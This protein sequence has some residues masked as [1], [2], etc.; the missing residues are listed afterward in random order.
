MAEQLPFVDVA[1]A[2]NPQQRCACVLVL[3]VS[4]SM[5]TIVANAGRDTG[6]TMQADGQTFRVVS[7]GTTRM[8][9]LNQGLQTL[10]GAL[11]E[12]PLA[13][14][15]VELAVVTFGDTVKVEQPFVT[16]A[17]FTP[18]ALHPSSSGGTPMG[19]AILTAIELIEERKKMYKSHSVPYLRPW[20]FLISDGMP[21][22]DWSEAAKRI[23]EYEDQKK[24]VFFAILTDGE[25][26]G[27][28]SQLSVRPVKRVD[29]VKYKELFEWLS[30]T[31]KSMSQSAP[32]SELQVKLPAPG[33]ETV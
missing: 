2:T 17:E 23:R 6:Q 15:R 33:W 26:V 16:A 11:I 18:P 8:D 14:Q 20:L 13:S 25:N 3:D 28:L 5:G 30:A 21:D 22:D 24:L 1:L 4:G 31:Q 10:K 19:K 7:G 9:L 27:V 29:S 32:G 12:D